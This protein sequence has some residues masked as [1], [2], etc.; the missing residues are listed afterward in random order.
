MSVAQVLATT[1]AIIFALIIFGMQLQTHR[2][3]DATFFVRYYSRRD[4]L[5]VLASGTIGVIAGAALLSSSA[6]TGLLFPSPVMLFVIACVLVFLVSLAVV[7]LLWRMVAGVSGDFFE[8]T[9]IPGLR[10]DYIRAAHHE[11]QHHVLMA[12]YKSTCKA[13]GVPYS[14][15]ADW[16][17]GVGPRPLEIKLG[18]SGQIRDISLACVNRLSR[19]INAKYP[20]CEAQLALGLEDLVVAKKT[21]LVVRS[22]SNGMRDSAI[23]IGSGEERGY[24]Q[25]RLKR[26]VR[27]VF[28]IGPERVH[29]GVRAVHES[30]D[31]LLR[32][33]RDGSDEQFRRYLGLQKDLVQLRLSYPEPA[34]RHSSLHRRGL[35][36]IIDMVFSYYRIVDVVI[37]TKD[38]E[39]V[40]DFAVFVCGLLSL[41]VDRRSCHLA[42]HT[43]GTCAHLYRRAPTDVSQATGTMASNL[44]QQV[45]LCL[46]QFEF[47][48]HG[49]ADSYALREEMPVLKA[50]LRWVLLLCK[51]ALE[52]CR[53]AE[54]LEFEELVFKFDRYRDLRDRALGF[55]TPPLVAEML[56]VID[57]HIYVEI[58]LAG[59]WL[60]LRPIGKGGQDE[61][62]VFFQRVATEIDSC[63]A[64]AGA[65]SRV[66]CSSTGDAELDAE[67]GIHTWGIPDD[68]GPG[69]APDPMNWLYDGFVALY[70]KLLGDGRP[71]AS[72]G[73]LNLGISDYQANDF[74]KRA[75]R[76]LKEE[77][78]SCVVIGV[79]DEEEAEQ[80]K[81][82]FCEF[83]R[84]S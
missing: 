82:V 69:G 36:G 38:H 18:R 16:P 41:A 30:H 1:A 34:N 51:T 24:A 52:C 40:D 35:P 27:R 56:D 28:R 57:L 74:K 11:L 83:L 21:A 78:V 54:A 81:K 26:L 32:T 45:R 14:Q 50:V 53:P 5:P 61:D 39:K 44:V 7:W 13:A 20:E 72:G 15:V 65:W 47:N 63:D 12:K 23:A 79:K 4:G 62:T 66:R 70:L 22:K 33:A 68:R 58:V 19:F 9:L 3:G 76:L 2:L 64:L 42:F 17:T 43:A 71:Q 37:D 25:K 31:L 49:E 60:H 80:R 8:E 6:R 46:W 73:P 75:D 10:Y 67:L 84:P 55:C 77:N 29:D 48:R 59:W